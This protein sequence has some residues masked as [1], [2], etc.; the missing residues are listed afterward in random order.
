MKTQHSAVSRGGLASTLAATTGRY[1]T[2]A[3]ADISQ[4]KLADP[5]ADA[6]LLNRFQLACAMAATKIRARAVAFTERLQ[7]RALRA[8]RSEPS[9]F[10]S[11]EVWVPAIGRPAAVRAPGAA[12]SRP[13]RPDCGR[14][15]T[16]KA[17]NPRRNHVLTSPYL[18]SRRRSRA[19]ERAAA[20]PGAGPV[21][22]AGHD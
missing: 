6:C 18:A 7:V 3:T 2:V 9:R 13:P 20:T 1:A 11:R 10:L 5:A 21:G 8:R 14:R 16:G 17:R 4:T 12:R 15:G 19:Q 22:C